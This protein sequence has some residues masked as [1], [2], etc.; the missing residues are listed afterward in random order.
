MFRGLMPA[1]VTPFDERGEVDLG[2]AEAVIDRFIE[3]GV[4]GV[5]P[6]G[7]TGEFSHLTG[8]E[9]KRFAEEVTRIV[10]G[11]APVVI[12]VGAGGR[13]WA[14][15]GGGRGGHGRGA[16]RGGRVRTGRASKPQWPSMYSIV[17]F[18]NF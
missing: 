11:R 1:M 2:A 18:Y 5:S 10:A 14:G 6:L 17:F 15:G 9:R 8:D 16:G 4:D 12:G 7:S 3:A 13:R